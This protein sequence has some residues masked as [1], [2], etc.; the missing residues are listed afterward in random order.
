MDGRFFL[1]SISPDK[2]LVYFG[3]FF[4]YFWHCWRFINFYFIIQSWPECNDVSDIY[5]V[6]SQMELHTK[7]AM[8]IHIGGVKEAE[9]LG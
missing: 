7:L 9:E 5:Y 6:P 1:F 3:P 2:Q 4:L 8:D